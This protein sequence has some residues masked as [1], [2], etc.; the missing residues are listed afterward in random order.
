MREYFLFIFFIFI[1]A[2]SRDM[3]VEEIYHK[4]VE[5]FL[6]LDWTLFLAAYSLFCKE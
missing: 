2:Y 5:L 6:F 4:F 3:A 1:A